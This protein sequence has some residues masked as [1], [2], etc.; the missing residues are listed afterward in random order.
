MRIKILIVFMTAM[1]VL[2][3]ALQSQAVIYTG[4]LANNGF[5]CPD[6]ADNTAYPGIGGLF[7]AQQWGATESPDDTVDSYLYWAV[8]DEVEAGKWAY[9]YTWHGDI[10]ELRHILFEV[11]NPWEGTFFSGT[12]SIDDGPKI[13]T[14]VPIRDCPLIST[15]LSLVVP[16][17]LI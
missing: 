11:S 13:F 7:A 1:F 2:G 4:C 15:V 3:N 8:S 17:R 5:S 16:I 14:A 9:E 12:T 6:T 10:K